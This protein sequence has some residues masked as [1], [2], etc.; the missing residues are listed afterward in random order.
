MYLLDVGL[1]G[2]MAETP[3]REMLIGDNV[4]SEF[5]GAFTENYVLEQMVTIEDLPIYYYSKDNSSQELDF[6]IQ[7]NNK[8][9]PVEVKAEELHQVSF[10]LNNKWISPL[11]VNRSPSAK[12]KF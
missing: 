9:T 6:I 11:N 2:A 10:V 5:K 12:R 7:T 1:F 4:F 3:P 8:V